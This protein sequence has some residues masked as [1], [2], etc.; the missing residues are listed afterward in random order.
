MCGKIVGMYRFQEVAR[1][2]YVAV[3]MFNEPEM[4]VVVLGPFEAADTAHAAE[5][6]AWELALGRRPDEDESGTAFSVEPLLR[7]SRSAATTAD[8]E[9]R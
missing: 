9:Q 5:D 4:G 2:L 7:P 8:Q 1:P 6:E 3:A